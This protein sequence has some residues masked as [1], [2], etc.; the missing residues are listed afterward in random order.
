MTAAQQEQNHIKYLERASQPVEWTRWPDP[1]LPL[2]PPVDE[3]VKQVLDTL[4]SEQIPVAD[5]VAALSRRISGNEDSDEGAGES[6]A[7]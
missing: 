3:L 6:T 1:P 2:L 4:K 7:S 5:F